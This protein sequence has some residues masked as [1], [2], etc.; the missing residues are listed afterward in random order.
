MTGRKGRLGLRLSAR[1]RAGHAAQVV[2][3]KKS[4]ILDLARVIVELEELNGRFPGVSVNVGQMA[5][6]IVPNSVPEEAWAAIDVRSPSAEGIRILP[7]PAGRAPEAAARRRGW[8]S[9]SRSWSR[10]RSWRRRNKTRPCSPSS[11]ERPG[12][13]T[14]PLWSSSAPGP[15]T[16]TPSRRRERPWWTAS[17]RSG[18]HDHSDR[19][20]LVRESLC[21]R[22]ALLALSL[23]AAW[24]RYEEGTLF[25]ERGITSR[26][27]RGRDL[28]SFEREIQIVIGDNV[29]KEGV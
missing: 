8:S 2:E 17:V 13:W 15:R 11:P 18:R 22:S 29:R 25:L 10:C 27:V 26:E 28:R 16:R 5:G 4:A 23:L 21:T 6:G 20:Y 1:G 9:R 24:R 3:G 12:G 19:E 14:S 7:L